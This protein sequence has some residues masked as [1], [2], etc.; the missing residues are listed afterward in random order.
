MKKKT[1]LTPVLGIIFIILSALIIGFIA[2]GAQQRTEVFAAKADLA[3][4]QLVDPEKDLDVVKIPKDAVTETTLTP[5]LLADLKDEKAKGDQRVIILGDGKVRLL[6]VA[7]LYKDLAIDTRQLA[8]NGSLE[9]GILSDDENLVGVTVDRAGAVVNAIRAGQVVDVVS[10][11]AALSEFAK[12]VCV[13]QPGKSCNLPV[14]SAAGGGESEG[15]REQKLQVVLAVPADG[16]SN[17][18]GA[19]VSLV[20]KPKCAV[21]PDGLIGPV[22]GAAPTSCA[23]PETRIAS[24]K[25]ANAPAP[26]TPTTETPTTPPAE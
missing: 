20:L 15:G 18:A 13:A 4:Y 21:S 16:A 10:G 8:L 24:G 11:G 6:P 19:E 2:V 1:S 9:L 22:K 5:D 3:P 12:V 26:T 14:D 23:V 7:P 17:V 25:G